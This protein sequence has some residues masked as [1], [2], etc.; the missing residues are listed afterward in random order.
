[1]S[2]KQ[3]L[4]SKTYLQR[5][6]IKKASSLAKMLIIMLLASIFVQAL[7]A[8]EAKQNI[9]TYKL[10]E[11][12]LRLYK[13]LQDVDENTNISIANS[14][15]E[16]NFALVLEALPYPAKVFTGQIFSIHLIAKTDETSVFDL[17]TS[18]D[19][20]PSLKVL[21]ED[22]KW[23]K[24]AKGYENT[25]Y[26]Q[27]QSPNAQLNKI[28]LSL[29][30]NKITFQSQSLLIK[31]INFIALNPPPNYSFLV[32][33]SLVV[34]EVKTTRYDDDH[35]ITVIGL[36]SKDA[37]LA[38]FHLKQMLKQGVEDIEGDYDSQR[39]FYFGISPLNLDVID[40]S[41]FD[42]TTK[43]YKNFKFKLKLDDESVST[44]SDLNPKTNKYILYKQIILLVL[45]ILFA[46]LFLFQSSFIALFISCVLLVFFMYITNDQ[47]FASLASG[48]RARILPTTNSTFFYT[49]KDASKVEI[50]DFKQDFVKVLL[51]NNKIGWVLKQDLTYI[52]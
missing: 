4:A 22:A 35:A 43:S 48:A 19:K 13:S 20:T 49:N 25:Y 46:L 21:N 23:Q 34:T 38:S 31:P 15:Y 45:I 9:K 8:N 50:L 27:A 10:K 30:R 3:V 52:N 26:F 51:P 42:L 32:A 29:S 18:F 44:Q 28:T 39:G 14:V 16:A 36:R 17:I 47:A 40:F 11:N 7:S 24:I 12:E 41:Y 5:I 2:T 1:M 6:K 33:N 37:N